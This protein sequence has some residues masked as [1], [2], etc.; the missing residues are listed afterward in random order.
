MYYNEAQHHYSK[1]QGIRES[2]NRLKSTLQSSISEQSPGGTVGVAGCPYDFG[3]LQ[4]T[5]SYLAG[6]GYRC[7]LQ[8]FV[9][10]RDWAQGNN[11]LLSHSYSLV[12]C[13][14]SV[15]YLPDHSLPQNVSVSNE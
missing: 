3:I 10:E 9:L 8:P 13:I 12:K 15:Y 14:N 11:S 7:I 6:Q 5:L 2:L 1:C 4:C